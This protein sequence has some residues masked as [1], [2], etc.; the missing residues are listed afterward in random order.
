MKSERIFNVPEVKNM[1]EVIYN[2]VKNYSE[3]ISF[4]GWT[5][6]KKSLDF[7]PANEGKKRDLSKRIV[8]IC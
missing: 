5:N 2:A 1:K 6:L 4:S 7:K 8:D 3:N